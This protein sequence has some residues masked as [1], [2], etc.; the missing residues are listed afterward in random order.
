MNA[1][2]GRFHRIV[3]HDGIGVRQLVRFGVSAVIS[4]KFFV[5]RVIHRLEVVPRGQVAHQ[6]FGVDP[7][8]FFFA[9]RER[10]HRHVGRLQPLVRQLFI[11]RHVGIA[12]NGGYDSRFTARGEFFDVSDNRLVV[13]V[14][15]RGVD[16]F[17]VFILNAFSVQER[18]QDLIGGAWV[19]VIGAEQEEALRA[20]A[21][22]AHQ[23]FHCRDRLLVRRGTCIEDIRRH[24]FALILHRV[25]EQPVEFFKDRQYRF[26]RYRCP[27][28]E[29]H[30][31]FILAQQLAGFLGK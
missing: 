16:L 18:A 22:F 6:R 20:A 5:F 31:D 13:A 15:K 14:A 25:E 21:I 1:D 30:R 24:L 7:A 12:V 19:D 23:V 11:E 4:D 29:D 9:H 26:T 2:I 17:N 27:A 8:Q 28:A 3:G 10:H